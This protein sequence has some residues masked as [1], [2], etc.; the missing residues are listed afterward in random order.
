MN[1]FYSVYKLSVV[2]CAKP[3]G[4]A[5]LQEVDEGFTSDYSD[6]FSA[7]YLLVTTV[8]GGPEQEVDIEI[9]CNGRIN[10]SVTL[11][12]T[13]TTSE[14]TLAVYGKDTSDVT[15][16]EYLLTDHNENCLTTVTLETR[17]ARHEET[18]D[19]CLEEEPADL[20]E[21]STDFWID[22]VGEEVKCGMGSDGDGSKVLAKAESSENC[23]V[24][25]IWVRYFHQE[26]SEET[27][28]VAVWEFHTTSYGEFT[29]DY[30]K[31]IFNL[32]VQQNERLAGAV[33]KNI[34]GTFLSS[35]ILMNLMNMKDK[36]R[37]NKIY[38]VS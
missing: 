3:Y 33:C 1:S 32:A 35:L 19:Y 13:H 34:S 30:K 7:L 12:L 24:L 21:W 36:M 9:P 18:I 6:N 25:S 17:Q 23:E 15:C 37:S 5:K 2:S 8:L 4:N 29:L 22:W 14:K 27:M 31:K 20:G 16:L 26:E 28:A 38:F 10:I 11:N